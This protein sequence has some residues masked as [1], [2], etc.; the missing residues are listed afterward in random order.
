MASL[1]AIKAPFKKKMDTVSVI[2][3]S[4]VGKC[5]AALLAAGI[6]MLALAVANLLTEFSTGLKNALEIHKGIGPYSGKMAV[7]VLFWFVS[8]A[9]LSP[10]L[11]KREVD[12]KTILKIFMVIMALATLLLY[13]P[14]IHILV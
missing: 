12:M 6:G 2:E 8:W 4:K 1:E 14:F 5:A 13:P 3:M 11:S 7:S 9:A 10:L